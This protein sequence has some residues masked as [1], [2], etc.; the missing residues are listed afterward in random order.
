MIVPMNLRK[1]PENTL[2]MDKLNFEFGNVCKYS[3]I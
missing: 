2:D 1:Y 3:N